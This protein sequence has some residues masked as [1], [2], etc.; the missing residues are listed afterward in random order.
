MDRRSFSNLALAVSA[1]A[2]LVALIVLSVR[3]RAVAEKP[4]L[5]PSELSRAAAAAR[6]AA[7]APIAGAAREA[8]AVPRPSRAAVDR[9]RSSGGEAG[10]VERHLEQLPPTAPPTSPAEQATSEEAAVAAA[11]ELYGTGDYET[12]LARATE[13]LKQDPDNERMLRIATSSNCIL[14]D[15]AGARAYFGRLS[16]RGQREIAR[17]CSRYGIDL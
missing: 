15:A 4:A 17:R 3:V 13:Y 5:D 7:G 6:A 11:S 9:Q 10:A 12:A 2:V 14:G 16:P 8:P 1:A